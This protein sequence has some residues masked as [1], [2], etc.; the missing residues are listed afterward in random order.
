MMRIAPLTRTATPVEMSRDP[1]FTRRI[2]RLIAVSATALGPISFLVIFTGHADRAASGLMVAGWIAMPALLAASLRKPRW[3]YLLII[4][5]GL[6]SASLLTVALGY[7]GATLSRIGWWVILAGVLA[8]GTLGGWFWY[9]W[10]PVPRSLDGP[11]AIG[12]WMLIV[13]HAGLVV[14]GVLLVALGEVL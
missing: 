1:G 2:K 5:A 14:V 6:V 10:A 4:P 7:D 8:G 11:L 12:R 3:R 13:V 9:R